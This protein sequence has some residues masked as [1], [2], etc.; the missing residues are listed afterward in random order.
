MWLPRFGAARSHS[1]CSSGGRAKS[2]Q[3]RSSTGSTCRIE[4]I[5]AATGDR[6]ER[7]LVGRC[8]S[9]GYLRPFP[10]RR[11]VT[12]VTISQSRIDEFIHAELNVFAERTDRPLQP[13]QLR[14]ILRTT[15]AGPQEVAKLLHQE[16][17]VRFARRIN[18][19]ELIPGWEEV[20]ELVAINSM[21][22]TSFREVRLADPE[23]GDVYMSVI[24]Q[25]RIRH[26]PITNL[27]AQA[28]KRLDRKLHRGRLGEGKGSMDRKDLEAWADMFLSSRV[29]TEMQM[30]NYA[31]MFQEQEMPTKFGILDLECRP[32][33][34]CQ[35]VIVEVQDGPHPCVIEVEN[36]CGDIRFCQAPRYVYYIML[37]LLKNAAKATSKAVT[38]PD[39]ADYL[40]IK[41]SVCASDDEVVIR[42]SDRARGFRGAGGGWKNRTWSYLAM[43]AQ[44]EEDC[45]IAETALSRADASDMDAGDEFSSSSSA[46]WGVFTGGSP[47]A[48]RGIG[49][50]MS[51]LY[52][53]FLGGHLTMVNLP[54]LGVDAYLFLPR[55]DPADV[56]AEVNSRQD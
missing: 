19:I 22:R 7:R 1:R 47:L 13:L 30:A 34:I 4:R 11:F 55:I 20:P 26:L 28:L 45:S 27:V 10:H 43:C 51:R 5:H 8:S 50:P 40:P 41:V 23:D 54:G 3:L 49:L 46:P 33:D 36:P 52:A 6:A 9:A 2:F 53:K 32:L 44:M 48:G 24:H 42:V 17:P 56:A 21:H 39:E 29:S 12:G 16:L 15:S 37:E 38:W 18:S 14:E 35:Q 31:A 25:I